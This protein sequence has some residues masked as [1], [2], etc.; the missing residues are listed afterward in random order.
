MLLWIDNRNDN[1]NKWTGDQNMCNNIECTQ[2]IFFRLAKF[3]STLYGEN[4][5]GQ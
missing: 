3:D 1:E 2:F 4:T 5:W